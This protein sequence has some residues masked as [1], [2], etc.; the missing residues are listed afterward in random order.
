[1]QYDEIPHFSSNSN[2]NQGYGYEYDLFDIL[3]KIYEEF[4]YQSKFHFKG[5]EYK[6]W[7]DFLQ[8][9]RKEIVLEWFIY[10]LVM[11]L[12]VISGIFIVCRFLR[13]IL[14]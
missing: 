8:N 13:W 14:A 12:Q 3:M 10:F 2:S 4:R 1:M 5:N 7:N 9:E 11:T 6:N